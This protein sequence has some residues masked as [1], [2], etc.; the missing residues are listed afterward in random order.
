MVAPG[1]A[2][3]GGD[4]ALGDDG[5]LGVFVLG[6]GAEPIEC[7]VGGDPAAGHQDPD[8]PVDVCPAGQ[9]GLEPGG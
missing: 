4:D 6:Q 5:Q 7:L 1:S 3:R 2:D 8:R 9:G